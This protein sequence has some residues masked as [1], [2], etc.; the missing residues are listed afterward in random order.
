M[1]EESNQNREM[2]ERREYVRKYIFIPFLGG[3]REYVETFY[4]LWSEFN[5]LVRKKI[6]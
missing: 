6:V 2:R 4:Q 5:S 1:L 3:R